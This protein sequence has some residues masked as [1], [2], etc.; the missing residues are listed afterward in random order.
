VNAVRFND[1]REHE[2]YADRLPVKRWE[3][4][5]WT[6]AEAFVN[7]L[8]LRIVKAVE[9]ENWNLVKRL[10]YLLVHSFYAKAIAV[11]RVTSNKGR[12]TPGVDGVTWE[13][14]VQKLKSIYGLNQKRYQTSPLKRVYIEKF[15]KKEKRPLSIPTM[16]DRAMQALY[17]MALEPIAET[18]ADV[19]SFGFRKYRSTHDAMKHI[20]NL[21]ARGNAPIWVIEG[22]IKACFDKISHEWLLGNIPMDKN[23]LRKFLKAGFVYNKE[24]FPTEIGAPQGG[25]I[26]PTLA[27]MTL[28]GME[29]IL[30]TKYWP[31]GRTRK[32]QKDHKRNG[33]NLIR[34]ADD[35]IITA[36]DKETA[37][38]I[39][40]VI[41]EF[42][43]LRG[44]TLSPE[45]TKITTVH[46]GF[47][48]LGWNF[49]KYSNKLIVKPSAKSIHKVVTTLSN[50]IKNRKSDTQTVLIQ[51]LNQ[52]ITGWANYHQAACAKR[53]F[54]NLDYVVWEMLSKWTK[55]R[56]RGKSKDWIV[57]NYWHQVGTRNWVFKT[58]DATLVIA[59]DTPIVRHISLKLDKNPFL[60][61]GFFEERKARQRTKRAIAWENNAAAHLLMMGS[62]RLSGVQ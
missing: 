35:F 53:T 60:D 28:D 36:K 15:G 16:N 4:I 52:I 1:V 7:R 50:E 12:K 20:H 21:L 3:Q 30:A 44:L 58:K 57:H 31:M 17:L 54:G 59:Q 22:D 48:F 10:Q 61:T 38:D 5:D 19:V 46:E 51:R 40:V 27:N 26:S 13:K 8:Q 25:I 62:E 41:R 14:S 42:L 24:L 43:A 45:K 2:S 33:V 55:R 29:D 11:K 9:K 39:I 32:D 18:T 34:F 37:E 47:D 6:C 56:H 49:R 23:M